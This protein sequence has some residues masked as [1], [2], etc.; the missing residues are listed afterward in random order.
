MN[1]Q[2]IIDAAAMLGLALIIGGVAIIHWP[3]A[4]IVSGL[5]IFAVA[6]QANQ[7]RKQRLAEKEQRHG[8]DD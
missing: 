7:V 2:T 3:S 1:G 5:A 4:L 8:D 6:M